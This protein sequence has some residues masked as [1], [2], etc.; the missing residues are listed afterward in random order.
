VKKPSNPEHIVPLLSVCKD[1]IG[2]AIVALYGGDTLQM[3]LAYS[4]ANSLVSTSRRVFIVTPDIVDDFVYIKQLTK[5]SAVVPLQYG[6]Y[7]TDVNIL[8]SHNVGEHIGLVSL[9]TKEAEERTLFGRLGELL[10]EHPVTVNRLKLSIS[11]EMTKPFTS[12]Q[13]DVTGLKV[14]RTESVPLTEV[15]LRTSEILPVIGPR[16]YPSLCTG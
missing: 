2:T 14:S 15:Q 13:S 10:N 12:S 3:E 4:I 6:N 7:S 8:T 11:T 1:T 5:P 16:L 9:F